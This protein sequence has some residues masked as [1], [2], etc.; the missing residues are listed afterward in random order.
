MIK[1]IENKLLDNPS[2]KLSI[3]ELYLLYSLNCNC[4]DELIEY[5]FKR[6]KYEDFC[7]MFGMDTIACTQFDINENTICYIGDLTIDKELPTYN[8]KYIYGNLD[9]E[10]EYLY[11]LEN[12]KIIFGSANFEKIV[13]SDGLENLERVGIDA[14]FSNLINSYGLES[15]QR[16]GGSAFFSNLKSAEGLISL[17]QILQYADFQ[18]LENAEGLNNLEYIG[19][20]FNFKNLSNINGLE[21]LENKIFVELFVKM[22]NNIK[23]VKKLLIKSR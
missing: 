19:E 15:L 4:I 13:N 1:Q 18:S 6:D 9:Y 14:L 2:C 21:K 8:L 7:I 12:L 11:N 10:L 16:I 5:R 17:T 23:K 20:L 3:E 22:N